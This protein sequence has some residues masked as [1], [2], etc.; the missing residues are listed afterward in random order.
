M[1]FWCWRQSVADGPLLKN[2]TDTVTQ[3][4]NVVKIR[5]RTSFDPYQK[6]AQILYMFSDSIFEKRDKKPNHACNIKLTTVCIVAAYEKH[7]L[8]LN[9]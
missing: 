2:T 1:N 9:Q 4:I 5:T 3:P 7:H 8:N 6:D